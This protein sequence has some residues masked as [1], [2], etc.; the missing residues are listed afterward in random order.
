M[1]LKTFHIQYICISGHHDKMVYCIS[2]SQM[3]KLKVICYLQ[4]MRYIIIY[5]MKWTS[6]A[7]LV[8]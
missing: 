3:Q 6:R 1:S 8:V 7:A 2:N 4:Y 5:K